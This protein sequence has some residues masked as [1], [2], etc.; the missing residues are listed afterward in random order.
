M[1]PLP[2]TP[3]QVP[4]RH[5]YRVTEA[6]QLL[7]ISRSVLYEQIRAGRLRSV[8]VGRARLIPAKAIND[9]VDL[10]IRE[11]EEEFNDQAA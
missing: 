1:R 2:A 5:L 10:L 8:K 4:D 6:M 7:S 11:T 3:D 9:Y